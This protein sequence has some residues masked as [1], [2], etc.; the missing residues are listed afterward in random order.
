MLASQPQ[1]TTVHAANV[2]SALLLLWT[3]PGLTEIDRSIEY[4]L[5]PRDIQWL[6]D[7]NKANPQQSM[8]PFEMEL[9]IDRLEKESHYHLNTHRITL[10][11]E[12]SRKRRRFSAPASQNKTLKSELAKDKQDAALAKEAALACPPKYNNPTDD[13]TPTTPTANTATSSMLQTQS[14]LPLSLD[15]STNALAQTPTT[16][17]QP[18]ASPSLSATPNSTLSPAPG[19]PTASLRPIT[20]TTT[21]TSALLTPNAADTPTGDTVSVEPMPLSYAGTV[22]A[23][24]CHMQVFA[25]QLPCGLSVMHEPVEG[26]DQL[27]RYMSLPVIGPAQCESDLLESVAPARIAQ[28]CKLSVK[29]VDRVIVHWLKLRRERKWRPLLNRFYVPSVKEWIMIQSPT[30]KQQHEMSLVMRRKFEKLRILLD[31]IRKR[32]EA[33]RQLSENL[34]DSFQEEVRSAGIA[35]KF[36]PVQSACTSRSHV[37]PAGPRAV[38]PQGLPP[39]AAT[40]DS[41]MAAGAELTQLATVPECNGGDSPIDAAATTDTPS[42]AAVD[43]TTQKLHARLRVRLSAAIQ[44]KNEQE[45]SAIL[46]DLRTSG[47]KRLPLEVLPKGFTLESFHGKLREDGKNGTTGLSSFIHRIAGKSQSLNTCLASS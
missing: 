46:D 31:M 20:S 4:N 28:R 37:Q 47:V 12:A 10:K 3:V 25:D 11:P 17:L 30:V 1:H 43:T 14:A 35:W 18:P 33:K 16:A 5:E 40:A 8:A 38:L 15:T 42:A 24:D 44:S 45:L 29:C 19:T 9:I 27:T 23:R 2:S 13:T 6:L 39:A 32:E 34:I 41:T 7:F 22:E 21:P 26:A 36:E